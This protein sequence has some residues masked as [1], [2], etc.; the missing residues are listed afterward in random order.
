MS[1]SKKYGHIGGYNKKQKEDNERIVINSG[2][3]P[4][5][6]DFYNDVVAIQTKFKSKTLDVFRKD[7]ETYHYADF[8]FC[9]VQCRAHFGL[10]NNNINSLLFIK[11][12]KHA[13]KYEKY[14]SRNGDYAE[15]A[16]ALKAI[17]Y[18]TGRKPPACYIMATENS[19]PY[20]HA[21]FRLS[22]ELLEQGNV[23]NVETIERLKNYQ[24]N[25]YP[26]YF[27]GAAKIV[28]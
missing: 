10:Y 14:I 16:F 22:D 24:K 5:H 28:E 25:G 17:E 13:G 19:P 8:T 1:F 27:D 18:T 7:R 11:L 26:S 6:L 21:F 2:R 3:I 20:A 15:A 23:E 4:L 12:A 9:D